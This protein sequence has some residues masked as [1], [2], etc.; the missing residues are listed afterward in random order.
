MTREELMLKYGPDAIERARAELHDKPDGM[1]RMAMLM[2]RFGRNAEAI[3]QLLHEL[4]EG[5]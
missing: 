1:A 4:D 3:A 5:K 2:E